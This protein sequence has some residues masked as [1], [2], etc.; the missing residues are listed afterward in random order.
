MGEFASH[1][2]NFLMLLL[3]FAA[4]AISAKSFMNVTEVRNQVSD[5]SEFTDYLHVKKRKCTQFN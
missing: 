1:I 3:T 5:N 4:Q 2:R